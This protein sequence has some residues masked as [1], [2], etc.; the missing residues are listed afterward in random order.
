M[1]RVLAMF[2][3]AELGLSRLS[4]SMWVTIA[5]NASW[6]PKVFNYSLEE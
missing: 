4:W 6:Q 5:D 1:L 2:R 3:I